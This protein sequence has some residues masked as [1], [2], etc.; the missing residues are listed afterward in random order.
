M[1]AKRQ[2]LDSIRGSLGRGALPPSRR[3]ELEEALNHPHAAAVPARGTLPHP[4]QIALFMAMCVEMSASVDRVASKALVPAAI[5]SYLAS[6]NLPTRLVVAPA[7]QA[8]DWAAAPLLETR[9]GAALPIDPVSVTPVAAG[10]AE[11]GTLVLCSG[12]DSPT[13]LNFLPDTH[14]AVIEAGQVVGGY[15]EVWARLRVDGRLVP[16]NINMITGPSRTGDI[17]Q[18]IL[19]GAH[20]PRRLHVILVD[21][22]GG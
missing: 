19:L 16:R 20:G 15:E 14:I 2:I 6:Q 11:T 13:T 9:F 17:E 12:P 10:V 5:A 8:L 1:T 3:A 4:E 7:L 21:E 18:T 22:H